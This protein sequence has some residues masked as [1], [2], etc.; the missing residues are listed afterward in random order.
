M[1]KH[2]KRVLCLLAAA[3]MLLTASRSLTH[4]HRS[5]IFRSSMISLSPAPPMKTWRWPAFPAMEA[6]TWCIAGI[7]IP[8]PVRWSMVLR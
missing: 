4:S 2:A 8:R 3:L 7:P 6:V 5:L 1:R